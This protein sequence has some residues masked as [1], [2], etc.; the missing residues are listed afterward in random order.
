MRQGEESR[1]LLLLL[2]LLF[3][4]DAKSL[5][6]PTHR[7]P[8]WAYLQFLQTGRR[9]QYGKTKGSI[10]QA[11]RAVGQAI[12]EPGYRGGVVSAGVETQ[13]ASGWCQQA[14]RLVVGTGGRAGCGPGGL[15]GLRLRQGR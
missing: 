15:R 1:L 7:G 12:Q 14:G 9:R 4:Q 3:S 13:S 10:G 8:L 6:I 5:P 2:F 11:V